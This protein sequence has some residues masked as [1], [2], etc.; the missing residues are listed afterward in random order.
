MRIHILRVLEMTTLF[1]FGLKCYNEEVAINFW[2]QSYGQF[3]HTVEIE[4][5]VLNGFMLDFDMDC[6][7]QVHSI[8]TERSLIQ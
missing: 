4:N 7:D 2:H 6:L 3:W 1:D 5:H 8:T